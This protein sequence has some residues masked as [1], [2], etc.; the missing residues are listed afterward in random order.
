MNLKKRWESSKWAYIL[1]ARRT[2]GYSFADL[3]GY[4]NA[5]KVLCPSDPGTEFFAPLAHRS[6][7][8]STNWY[9]VNG[10]CVV[11]WDAKRGNQGGYG[12]AGCSCDNLN[13]P[14]DIARGPIEASVS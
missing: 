6:Y 13:D 4:W 7:E 5:A 10:C 14:R 2:Y 8:E 1:Y 9:C 11:I 12:P 3:I